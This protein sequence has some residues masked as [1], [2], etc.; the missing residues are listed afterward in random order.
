MKNKIIQ[1]VI[2]IFSALSILNTIS[3]VT[4]QK[5][6]KER[7]DSYIADLNDFN[8]ETFHLYAASSNIGKP[9]ITD[10]YVSFAPRTNYIL[11]TG[12]IGINIVRIGFSYEERKSLLEA[13][14]AYIAA[15]EAS[16][17]KDIKPTKKNAFTN[18]MASV[19]WGATGLGYGVETSYFTNTQFLEANKPYFLI[20]FGQTED[21]I[22]KVYSPKLF[23]YISPAQWEKIIEACSQDHL[24][25][26]CD[27]ILA[28]AEAF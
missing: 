5:T 11:I 8:I 22:S 28:E 3:C 10:F 1:T 25:A 27:Q 13:R 17:I 4:K 15:F 2:I 12:R 24:V 26:M 23:V 21:E 9:K 7:S 20:Q 18:G 19:E 16:L 14:N 6:I